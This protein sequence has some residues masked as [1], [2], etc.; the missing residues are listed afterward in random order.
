MLIKTGRHSRQMRGGTHSHAHPIDQER[1]A[2]DRRHSIRAAAHP[3]LFDC[4]RERALD[5][6]TSPAPAQSAEVT[7]MALRR[8][9]RVRARW[10]DRIER[11][12]KHAIR[13]VA[14]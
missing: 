10:L 14:R 11:D 3:D 1:H 5:A 6:A 13:C 8:R 7:A 9:I 4:D 12:S 2:P